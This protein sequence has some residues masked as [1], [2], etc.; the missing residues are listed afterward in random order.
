MHCHKLDRKMLLNT[1]KLLIHC[2]V[3]KRAM[4]VVATSLKYSDFGE[5][6]E[7]IKLT[8]DEISA[9]ER[10]EV[11]VKILASPMNPADINTI[12]GKYPV[13]PKFPAIG[14][15]ECVAEVISVGPDVKKLKEK[16]R[17]IPF[18]TGMGTWTTHTKYTE[19]NLLKIPND[20]G[21]AEAATV[22]V[23]PCT[24]YR[25]L[26]DFVDLKAGD[27]IIQNGANS[28]VGQLVHQICKARGI[29][30]VGVVR[31]RPNKDALCEYLKCLGATEVL[32]EGETRT[33]DI[34]K[35]KYKKPILGLNCIG[36][37]SATEV[38]RTLE[39]SGILVTYGGMSREPLTISTASL[40]FKDITLKGYWMTRWT[41]ENF[42][43]KERT[44]MFEELFQWMREDKLVAPIHEFV[45]LDNYEEGL[46]N[47]LT[48][49]GFVSKKYILKLNDF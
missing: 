43:S 2:Q 18:A 37:K 30:S 16:D 27:V 9:P 22:T 13:K 23:N 21:L 41:K 38:A 25:V 14:G 34:F 47:A 42:H 36:G 28:S 12:Q 35:K 4:S 11:L 1:R 6:V 45:T 24:A 3:T 31:D 19:D 20:I 5:P 39:N 32:I 49:E 26:K 7:V 40:I 44:T 10:N 17:V 8:K 29:I 33:T 48:Y 46:K 15:N